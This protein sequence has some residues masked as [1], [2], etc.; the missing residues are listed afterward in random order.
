MA[1]PSVA[2]FMTFDLSWLIGFAS[3]TVLIFGFQAVAR[4]R[5]F[6]RTICSRR[7]KGYYFRD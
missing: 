6:T 5:N 2:I 3:L 7:L 4:S 1:T